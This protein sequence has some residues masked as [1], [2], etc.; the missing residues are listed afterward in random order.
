MKVPITIDFNISNNIPAFKSNL[1]L[2]VISSAYHAGE[3]YILIS[4]S[5]IKPITNQT[6]QSGQVQPTKGGNDKDFVSLDLSF[7]RTKNGYTSRV[8]E[9]TSSQQKILG[10]QP[11]QKDN[12]ALALE[13][14]FYAWDI[15]EPERWVQRPYLTQGIPYIIPAFTDFLRRS[16]NHELGFQSVATYVATYAVGLE[17]PMWMMRNPIEL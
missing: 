1:L 15:R 17:T 4:Q 12:R 11:F 8:W 10:R 9:Q 3:V 14:G 5:F 7:G 6:S 2:N 13:E 16:L